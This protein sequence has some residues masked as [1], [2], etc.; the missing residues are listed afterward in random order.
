[1]KT[2][3]LPS[4]KSSPA[5]AVAGD[6]SPHFEIPPQNGRLVVVTGTGGLGY[7]TALSLAG[8]GA[9]VI[10]AGRNAAKGQD[11]IERIRAAHPEAQ[12]SF[13]EL[14]LANLAS[15]SDFAGRYA[16]AHSS[17]DVLVN[18]AGVMMPPKRQK[19][20]DGFELQFGTNYLGHY[21]LTAHLLPLLV[22]GHQ[23]RVVNVSSLAHRS[24][25]I[26]FDDLQWE[27][28]Y[29]PWEAYCQS[30]LAMLLFA[31]ELQRRS[32]ANG[33]G[34]MSNAA[35]PGYA[36]TELIANGPGL[37]GFLPK[38]SLLLKPLSQSAADGALPTLLA[39]AS[40]EAEGG[41]TTGLTDFTR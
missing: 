40:P 26:H 29:K 18:N 2:K 11:A 38:I 5:I 39:A 30:K 25:A 35:H 17:L 6:E 22:N 21:A 15:V 14:D 36:R 33:W 23:P 9:D 34:L 13:E 19:T 32:E 37:Q 41:A 31:L 20:A 27:R 16:N 8:A 24:G 10:L 28:R 1:M 3:T 7:E 12:I 4:K